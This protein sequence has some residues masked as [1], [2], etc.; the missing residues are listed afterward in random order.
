MT[1][2]IVVPSTMT[3]LPAIRRPRE[4]YRPFDYPIAED[5]F[6]KQQQVHWLHTEINMSPDVNDWKIKLTEPERR[7]IGNVLK[8]FTQTEVY[9]G[10][11]WGQRVSAW[12]PK[13]EIQSMAMT[14]AAFEAV[15]AAAY[16]H[17]NTTLGLEDFDAFLYEPTAAAKIDAVLNAP[18]AYD[19]T[20]ENILKSLGLYSAFVEGVSLF[21]AFSVL[22]S[23]SQR[24]LLKGVGQI[25]SWSVRDESLHSEAGCWLYRELAKDTGLGP[26]LEEFMVE[27]ARRIVQLEHDFVDMCFASGSVPGLSP[28][29][30]NTMIRHRA[31][32]KLGD[33]GISA[34]PF[35]VDAASLERMEWFDL[36][37]AGVE[38]QD[39]FANRPTAY[40]KG[41]TDWGAAF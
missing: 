4:V 34:R 9:V 22:L 11:Y 35:V 23:F 7:V 37:I 16:A 25:V 5:Y 8:G 30:V 18:T 10:E 41:Q 15:H 2:A 29:D 40:A 26:Q 32:T 21:S 17:L 20:D 38:Y 24:N 28:E 14:F 36:A 39:F 12:F 33:L 1:L 3:P 13:P 27:Q 6:M 31:N 19:L